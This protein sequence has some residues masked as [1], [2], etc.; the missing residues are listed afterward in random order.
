MKVEYIQNKCL[1]II[2]LVLSSTVTATD[3]YV[4]ATSTGDG[5]GRDFNNLITLTNVNTVLKAGDRA[6]LRG[7][8][9]VDQ[10]IQ[11]VNSG[12]QGKPIIYMAYSGEKP[13]FRGSKNGAIPILI[14]LRDR[15]YITVDGISAD[16]EKIYK[17]SHIDTWLSFVNSNYCIVRNSTFIR[18]EGWAAIDFD[19]SHYNKFIN[20]IVDTNG[21]WDVIAWKG[22]HDD[23]GTMFKLKNGSSYNLIERNTF[24]RSGHDLGGTNPS[25]GPYNIIRNNTFDNDWG[26]YSGAA[27]TF[28]VGDI[29]P[30]DRVGNRTLELKGGAYTL[31][32]NNIFKNVGESV[33][34][35]DVAMIKVN[36][37]KTIVRNNLFINANRDGIHTASVSSAPKSEYNRI[38]HN[39]FYN[40]GGPAWKVEAF[41]SSDFS[42]NNN[43]FKNNIVY[44]AHV[45]PSSSKFDVDVVFERLVSVWND[46]FLNNKVSNNCFAHDDALSKQQV[47]TDVSGKISLT[48][49]ETAYPIYFT[50][51]IQAVPSFVTAQPQASLDDYSLSANSPCRNVGANLTLTT[52]SGS[53]KVIPVADVSYFSDG[54]GLIPGDLIRVGS[55]AAVRIANVNYS[56]NEI[57]VESSISWSNNDGIN[58]NYSGSK[59]DIGLVEV[60]SSI[61]TNIPSPPQSFSVR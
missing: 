30:G 2:L 7:G 14:D 50:N 44:K 52:T 5:S 49:A 26:V 53:G 4:G 8:T 40:L 59:P 54:R 15:S 33:D 23:S 1:L 20:N 22:V 55:N 27:F 42:P 58:L 37:I 51:N 48:Q 9:Y 10:I 38:F 35:S 29:Q 57:T 36:G 24:R 16:G 19:R 31:V 6:L 41:S 17:D 28:K 43:E 13:E 3:Y 56:K 25:A 39:V 61:N 12:T 11:P 47:F 60:G 32:E 34:N 18:S 21:T 46:A 45:N